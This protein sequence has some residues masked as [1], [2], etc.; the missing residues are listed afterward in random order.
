M[1][2][3]QS[4]IEQE[5]EQSDPNRRP[6]SHQRPIRSLAPWPDILTN[7]WCK[8]LANLVDKLLTLCLGEF[9]QKHL[10]GHAPLR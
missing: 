4:A 7:H 10:G 1:L 5:W 2:H 3:A 8:N 9:R 6:E